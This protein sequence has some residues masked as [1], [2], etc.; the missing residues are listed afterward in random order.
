MMEI[1]HL[2]DGGKDGPEGAEDERRRM[3]TENV[4]RDRD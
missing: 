2:T 4:L 3:S 1:F